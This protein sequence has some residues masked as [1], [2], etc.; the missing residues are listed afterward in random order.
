MFKGML[1]KILC[2]II[3][4]I[5]TIQAEA[6]KD[7]FLIKLKNHPQ[8]DSFRVELLIDACV[9]AV[10]SADSSVL[11][12]ALEAES[13]SNKIKYELGKI[14]S[15]NSIGNYYYQRSAYVQAINNYIKA[16]K[17]AEQRKDI[18][19]IIIGKS[20]LA[21][22]YN[23]I[24]KTTESIQLL[25]ECNGLLLNKGD[26][27]T[28]KRAAIL[29][30]LATAYASKNMH[31]TAAFYYEKVY[32]ICTLKGI[33]FGIAITLSNLGSEYYELNKYNKAIQVL[34]KADIIVNKMGY[35]F[36]KASVYKSLGKNYIAINQKEKGIK[37]LQ[38]AVSIAREN[39]DANNAIE[40]YEFL[41][42][43][44]A[45]LNDYYNAYS[46][47]LQYH[48]LK[49]SIYN[50]EKDKTIFELNTQYQTEKK[51][52][53]ISLLKKENQVKALQNKQKN[54]L[55]FGIVGLLLIGSFTSFLLFTRFRVQQQNK[56]LAAKV[57]S[58]EFEKDKTRMEL[59]A[60]KSQMNP[61]FIFNALNSIQE[62]IIL[63]DKK[64]ANQFMGKY[65]DL[66]RSTLNMSD[67]ESITIDEEIKSLEL[68]LELEKLRFEDN[69]S[70]E[71][72]VS[73]ELLNNNYRLPAMLIQPYVENA[74][75]HG[76]LHQ[77]GPKTVNIQFEIDSSDN[78]I[79]TCTIEDNGIGRVRSEAL[80]A[81]RLKKHTSFST[82][83]TKKRLELLNQGKENAIVVDFNDLYDADALA[84]GTKV[85]LRIATSQPNTF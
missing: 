24:N 3:L 34:E 29:T 76:L 13:I 47:A 6:Q 5:S 49:D 72:L 66:V 73:E 22:V 32:E 68:Y 63:N 27:L 7:S 2:I 16:L 59:T 1:I 84:K 50:L 70:Y 19:N 20:N 65:A 62:F 8:Q 57:S 33:T 82:G 81:M 28:Q 37:N 54:Y 51:E 61:H 9:N 52:Q 60:L 58:I 78:S 12:M 77:Q 75:K 35:D 44:Y 41:H 30:N 42:K 38:K 80:N 39:K 18:D 26:S 56:L 79:I 15:L 74:I 69:F 46:N 43:V 23:R 83:A 55:I 21:N 85:T 25:K 64:K 40:S 4:I 17:L 67:K 45:N 36:L 11:K 14:R 53:T 71:V 31:D 48:S 10:F